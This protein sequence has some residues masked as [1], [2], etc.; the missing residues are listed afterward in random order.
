MPRSSIIFLPMLVLNY[1]RNCYNKISLRQQRCCYVLLILLFIMIWIIYYLLKLN[2][3]V[4]MIIHSTC[5]NN[6]PLHG[7]DGTI[8]GVEVSNSNSLQKYSN[9]SYFNIH[10]NTERNDRKLINLH[11]IKGK[12]RVIMWGSHHKTGTY[13]A[14][15]LFSTIC[16]RMS[17]CCIFHVTKESI[18]SIKYS[19]DNDVVHIIGHTHWIWYPEEL[20]IPYKFIHF[21][22]QPLKKITSGYRYHKDGAEGWCKKFITYPKLC[23]NKI[24]NKPKDIISREAVVK[25]CFNSHLCET[26][27]RREHEKDIVFG[28]NNHH[29]NY[30]NNNSNL[31]VEY[32]AR[33][34]IEYDFLCKYLGNSSTSIMDTLLL[35]PPSKGILIEAAL[36]YYENLR[37]ARIYNHTKYDPNT[38]NLDLDQYMNNY[39]AATKRL[40]KFLDLD[41]SY[42]F[43]M[44]L[45]YDLNF[46]DIEMSP[47][48]RWTMSNPYT[49]HIDNS[50]ITFDFNGELLN[51]KEFMELYKPIFDM[52]K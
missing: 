6:N 46:Y 9:Q 40:L 19:L 13:L 17:W 49:N 51:N 35:N 32:A 47:V 48:Y 26:C 37:M 31:L 10:H 41:K 16:A 27:C 34:T 5:I 28:Y 3:E 43:L 22:R 15:K 50:H 36:D 12:N 2:P 18:D 20:G 38:L 30:N 52:M 14:Q 29:H 8:L 1:L 4:D 33:P 24:N 21:Y 44:N 39:Q 25:Y 42:N 45:E 7:W 11:T 23:T